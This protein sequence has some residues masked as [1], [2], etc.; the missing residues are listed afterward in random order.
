MTS[1]LIAYAMDFSSFLIQRIKE[2]NLIKNIILFGSV[3]RGDSGKDSDVDIFIDIIKDNEKLQKEIKECLDKFMDS[4]KYK[5]YW[6]PLGIENDISLI[7]G[8]LNKWKE[9]KPSIIA[10]GF[11]LYGKF[12]PEVKEGRHKTYFIWENIRPNSKRVLFNKQLFGFKA[13]EKFY[14]GLIQKYN[15]ERLGK[16]CIIVPL[17]HSDVF[18]N[19]FRKYKVDVKIK[20]VLEYV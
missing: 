12:K 11:T 3:S 10:N 5:N 6:K 9:L 17:E 19:L 15:G 13:G 7:I 18:Q 2:K 20:K 14:S 4:S 8:E 16:G 1:K